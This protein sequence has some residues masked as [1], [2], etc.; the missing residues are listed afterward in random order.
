MGMTNTVSSFVWSFLEQGGSKAI[1]MVVQIILARILS[2]H[3]FGVLA[4]L[5][6]VTQI[7]DSVAQSGLGMALIQKT[8]VSPES[9]STAWWLSLGF[10]IALYIIMVLISPYVAVFYAMPGLEDYLRVL[11]L[12]IIFNSMNSIQRSYLQRSMNFKSIFKAS[13]VAALLSGLVGI[14]MAY[15]GFGVWALVAQ[16]LLQGLFVCVVMWA[17]LPWHPKT[18]FE[19]REAKLLFAYG[20]KICVTGVLNVIYTGMTE[21][22]L[23]RACPAADR[24]IDSPGRS[25][26]VAAPGG[27]H[28][29]LA[30]GVC[31]AGAGIAE[32][33]VR[34][35]AAIKNG[36]VLGTF[37]TAP[38]CFLLASTARPLV[39]VLLTEKWLPC[40]LVFQLTCLSSSLIIMQLVN[41]R[42]YMALGDS[43]LY[44]RLQIIKCVGGGIVLWSTAMI[45][46]DIY[47]TAAAGLVVMLVSVI[48]VDAVPAKRMYGYGLFDQIHDVV[49]TFLLS[50]S[51]AVASLFVGNFGLGYLSDLLLQICAFAA[52]FFA[53]ARIFRFPQLNQ[54]ISLVSSIV[55]RR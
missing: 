35:R 36:L 2:P 42:A 15:L 19:A 50:A 54:T 16:S 31:R 34:L 18:V 9:Y 11:G 51:A 7:A 44:M 38:V 10:S 30:H 29:A 27:L 21:L 14:V 13:T 49:P 55:R 32:D 1:A 3:D 43:A 28:N 45:T 24:G 26:P 8:D 33:M 40:V 46:R 52:V 48:C 25:A 5:L 4:I 12:V 20:W 41:L 6:V 47:A 37:L 39:V 17:Q 22:I 53:G 23:G